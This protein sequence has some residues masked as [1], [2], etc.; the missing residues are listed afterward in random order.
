MTST[1][2]PWHVVLGA[3][4]AAFGYWSYF[5]TLAPLPADMQEA[6]GVIASAEA[7]SHMWFGLRRGR[8]PK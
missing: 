4:L 2:K 3:V 1:A 6:R 7:N 5:V 8:R